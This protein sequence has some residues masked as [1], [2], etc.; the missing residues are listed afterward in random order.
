MQEPMTQER[1]ALEFL[2]WVCEKPGIYVQSVRFD[3]VW[4]FIEGFDIA[5][6]NEPLRGFREW[7]CTSRR[8]WSNAPWYILVR[9]RVYSGGTDI[10]WIPADDEHLP[11]ISETRRLLQAFRL[12]RETSGLQ[13]ILDDYSEL[14]AQRDEQRRHDELRR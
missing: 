6:R 12:A 13:K 2:C 5:R 10:R 11:L 4:S 8:D 1:D 14:E 9:E 3:T 7:L